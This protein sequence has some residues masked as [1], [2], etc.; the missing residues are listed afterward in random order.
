MFQKQSNRNHVEIRLATK[1][2]EQLP[3]SLHSRDRKPYNPGK[4]KWENVLKP[5]IPLQPLFT[6]CECFTK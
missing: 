2:P 6:N 1:G 5:V 3:Q 4:V